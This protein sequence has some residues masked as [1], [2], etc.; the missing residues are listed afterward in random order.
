MPLARRRLLAGATGVGAG[1]L[2]ANPAFADDYTTLRDRW[3]DIITGVGRINP[4][5][6]EFPAA[7]ARLDSSAASARALI[8][9]TAGRT[10][11]FTDLALQQTSDSALITQTYTRLRTLAMAWFTPGAA[12]HGDAGVLS[13]V[14]AGLVTTGAVAYR[15]GRAEF[16]N[17]WDWEIGSSRALADCLVLLDEWVPSADRTRYVAALRHY[18]PDPFNMYIDS[19]KKPSTGANRVDLCQA[20][21]VEGIASRSA[22]RIQRGAAGL[23]T[24]CEYVS[25]G[26]G[27]WG[28][29]SFIQHANVAYTGTYGAVLLSGMSKLLALLT[30]S[31]WAVTDPL[32]QNLYDSIERGWAPLIHNGR[33]MSMVNGRAIAR[34]GDEH[35]LGHGAIASILQLA[36]ATDAPTA[37]RWRQ[38]CRG[39]YDRDTAR[40]PFSGA[41]VARTA[42]VSD[43]LN[44]PAITAAPEPDSSV[45]FRNMARAVHRRAGWAFAISMCS[46][47]IARYEAMNGENLRGFHTGAGMTYLYDDDAK[48]YSDSFWPTVDPYR[49]P[50]TTVDRLV[51]ADTQGRGLPTARWAG[52]PVLDGRYSGVGLNLQAA[53]TDLKG[54]KSWF[55]FDEYVVAMGSSITSTSGYRVETFVE[56]RNLHTTGT[57]ALTVDGAVWQ[58]ALNTSNTWTTVRWAHMDGVAGY[59]FP[60]AGP[61]R[62]HRYE[63][64]G[65]FRDINTAGSTDPITRRYLTVWHDHGINPTDARYIYLV[66]P[67]ATAERTAELSANPGVTVL[68]NAPT[69][70]G[71][72][73]PATGITMVN[74]WSPTTVAGRITVDRSCGVIVQELGKTLKICMA[75]PTREGGVVRVSVKPSTTGWTLS[76]KD[77][78]VT[79]VSTGTTIVLDISAGAYGRT[80]GAVFTRP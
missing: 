52:G 48:A 62:A 14:L 16:D 41:D 67:K 36:H 12:Y 35:S 66:V 25:E 4:D 57:N 56:N 40:T 9:R 44:D 55:C 34:T 46:E 32:L 80:Y 47:R 64:T 75:Q 6:P 13:D 8:D 54:K 27:L 20:A 33:M 69:V 78:T 49:M 38:A 45:V 39:W 11:V 76:S 50:G 43:L 31:P 68:T 26:D 10:R 71:V 61:M 77:S 70:Q 53:L 21:I 2:L 51:I 5:L 74:F 22:A 15:S 59:V 1:L 65:R 19:R 63:R 18:V 23:P 60:L 24:V 73:Q 28:D 58:G 72:F 42:L 7:I 79:V 29:G 17:W 3:R 37:T 30:G